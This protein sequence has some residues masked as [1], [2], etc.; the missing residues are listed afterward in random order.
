MREDAFAVWPFHLHALIRSTLRGADDNTD[1]RWSEQDWQHAAAR[2][3]TTLGEQWSSS[4]VGGRL[5]LVAALRQGLALA[6]DHRLDLDWL[7]EAAWAYVGDWLWEPVAPP[8]PQT[9]GT[10][11]GAGELQTPADALIETLSALARRQHEHRE[12]TVQRLTAVLDSALLP[13]DL[14]DLARYYQ[15]KAQRDLGRSA[16]SR[17]GMQQVAGRGGRLAPD[18][19]RGLAHLARLAG[20]FPTALA[21][22]QTLGREGSQQRVLGDLWW[23]QGDIE[24]AAIAYEA[25]RTDAEQQGIA[26]ERATAQAQRAFVLAFADPGR[27]DDELDLAEQLLTGLDLRATTLTTKIAALIRDAGTDQDIEDRA[28]ALRAESAA[29]GIASA[30]A[31]LELAV[32]FHHAVLGAD[33]NLAAAVE[34]PH[35][36]TRSSDHTYYSDITPASWPAS[37]PAH[38]PPPSG[39]TAKMPPA[40]AGEPCHRP[41][42]TPADR[43]VAPG[44]TAQGP[45]RTAGGVTW[46]TATSSGRG[47]T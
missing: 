35:E 5:L 34:R 37:P 1:D 26:G 9:A 12:R 43:G 39:S 16:D 25:A 24:R 14:T 2:A 21:T 3:H 7:T 10:G 30:R 32:A 47:T 8:A 44:R 29:A 27:A 15:A 40:P 28:S 18:A 46:Q 19:R 11:A 42:R 6:R 41:A 22:A 45:G 17:R 13:E 23:P 4:T 36:L 38:P 33:D 20:D 31:T